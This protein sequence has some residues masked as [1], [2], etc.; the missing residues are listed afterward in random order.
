M[1]GRVRSRPRCWLAAAPDRNPATIIVKSRP[2]L[3]HP[4]LSVFA[5]LPL[6]ERLFVRGR[7]A[8]A[9][10]EALAARAE[11]ARLLDVGCGH[12]ALVALLAVG[13]PGRQVVGIDPDER[14]IEWARASVGR[15]P[16]VELR[17]CTIEVLAAERSG[18]FDTV[19]VA[20][21]LYL[22]A[23]TAWPPFLRA[24]HT[25]LRPGGR[26]VLKEAEDDG[27]WRVKKALF[28]EQLMVR[29]LRRTHSSGAVGFAPRAV[30][31]AAV[32]EAGFALEE[33]VPLARGYSTPHLLLVARR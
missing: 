32:R 31:E 9:P 10:L 5:G 7:L 8:T 27:S 16:N 18:A 1:A 21:V 22:L 28:Q 33:T 17:A 15:L 12:G 2:T 6:R 26:L 24:A 13:F 11:G 25:L 3:A 14:K 29:L 4:S 23:A 20:D 30:L 19:L